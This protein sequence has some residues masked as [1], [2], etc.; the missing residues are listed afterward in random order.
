MAKVNYFLPINFSTKPEPNTI[1]E[2]F[3]FMRDGD[4]YDVWWRDINVGKIKK[5]KQSVFFAPC[6]DKVDFSDVMMLV[7]TNRLTITEGRYELK[8]IDADIREEIAESGE[9]KP[10]KGKPLNHNLPAVWFDS[11]GNK[12][13]IVGYHGVRELIEPQYVVLEDGTTIGK[14]IGEFAYRSITEGLIQYALQLDSEEILAKVTKKGRFVRQ[15]DIIFIE[16][17]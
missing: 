16:E 8:A 5:S 4:A 12:I 17:E 6:M 13:L 2:S 3:G 15:A 1:D 9:F 11:K 7:G 14:V 10:G